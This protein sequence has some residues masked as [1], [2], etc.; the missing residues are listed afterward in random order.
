[1]Q[2]ELIIWVFLSLGCLIF[3]CLQIINFMR[4]FGIKGDHRRRRQIRRIIWI[5]VLL[6]AS[7][8]CGLH[9]FDMTL[10]APKA[11]ELSSYGIASIVCFGLLIGYVDHKFFLRKRKFLK[12]KN[13]TLAL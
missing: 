12:N 11:F 1:M 9:A 7:F 4:W 13:A 6:V 2:T 10:F 5:C 3:L 8:V